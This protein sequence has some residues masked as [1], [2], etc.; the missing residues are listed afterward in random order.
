[1]DYVALLP[2]HATAARHEAW[3]FAAIKMSPPH[4]PTLSLTRK[5]EPPKKG[6]V[7]PTHTGGPGEE[8]KAGPSSNDARRRQRPPDGCRYGG[9]IRVTQSKPYDRSLQYGHWGKPSKEEQRGELES[10]TLEGEMPRALTM[11]TTSQVRSAATC[12]KITK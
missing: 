2:L 1:M 9:L 5:R 12:N 8:C 6:L 10:E 7:P 4:A 3:R 11:V